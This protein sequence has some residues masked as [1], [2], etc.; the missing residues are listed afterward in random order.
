M[1]DRFKALP[2]WVQSLGAICVGGVGALAQ[3]PFGLVPL[4]L[5]MLVL[6][7]TALSASSSLRDATR[8]GWIIGFGYF[9]ITLQWITA[10]F[11]VDAQQT[12][13]MAPF[14]LILMSGGMALFWGL[15]FVLA[16]FSGRLWALI[17]TWPLVELL[18]AYVFTGFPW[19]TPPQ[20]LVD[21][22]GGQA[23]AWG[24]PHGVMLVMCAVAFAIFHSAK[25]S[26]VVTFGVGI[27]ALAATLS[28]PLAGSAQLTEHTVRLVQP[29]APQRDKWNP[30]KFG[31]FINRLLQSTQAGDVPDLVLWSETALPYLAHNAPGILQAAGEAGRGAPVALG[32]LRSDG[33][34]LYNS[35]V[36]LDPVGQIT[37][38]YDKHHLVPF[39]EYMPFR[40][41]LSALGL[42]AF[43]DM[44]GNGFGEGGGA[45][46]LD[47]GPLGKGLPLICYEAVFAHDVGGAVERSDFLIQLTNDA[48]FGTFAGPEQHLA[49]AKMRS[50][51]QGLPMARAANTG[52]S[53]MIDPYGRVLKSLSLNEAGYVD[54]SL[55]MPL[56][57]TVYSKLGDLPIALLLIFVT[58]MALLPK[59]TFG[60]SHD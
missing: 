35:M 11:Q 26:K 59:M 56:P 23:L 39:G 40:P 48:W 45:K 54:A 4:I 17:F 30:E 53:A 50:I 9:L 19:G 13:W 24:G 21:V 28:P 41:V 38:T 10:P 34:T 51:E 37:A 33:P 58:F 31:V 22:L 43:V 55:P 16:G 3:Q 32:I 15:A 46:T 25:M 52:I 8:L 57:P 18:R 36:V 60:R 44:F 29:N 7:F 27:V 1:I 6:G 49:Q 20:A 2:L 47:F 5:V 12:A 42:H 14:A